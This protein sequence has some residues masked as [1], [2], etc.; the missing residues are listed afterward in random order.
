MLGNQAEADLVRNQLEL[1]GI[2]SV[3]RTTNFG[4]GSMD[5]LAGGQQEILVRPEDFDRARALLGQR[6]AG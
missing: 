1:E 3:L 6:P 2:P 4:A 5:G